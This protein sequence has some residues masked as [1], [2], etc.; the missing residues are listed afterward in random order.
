MAST[1]QTTSTSQTISGVSFGDQGSI[2]IDL[3]DTAEVENA[4]DFSI[5]QFEYFSRL[6]LLAI[7]TYFGPCAVD[8]IAKRKGH[9]GWT[10]PA[11]LRG[12]GVIYALINDKDLFEISLKENKITTRL[13]Q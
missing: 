13:V 10:L 3:E 4:C 11:E 12:G 9:L 8:R 5:G 6:Q 7:K 2:R 1:A